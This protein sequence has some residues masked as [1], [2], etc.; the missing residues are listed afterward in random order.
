MDRKATL[1]RTP[2]APDGVFGTYVSDSGFTA[3]SLERPWVDNLQG[4]SC[5]PAGTYIAKWQ[6]SEKHGK[7]LYHLIAVPGREEIEMHP[8]NVYEQLRGCI[9]LGKDVEIF[10]AGSC[11]F[12]TPLT[13]HRGITNSVEEMAKFEADLRDKDGEQVDFTIEILDG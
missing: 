7:N 5:V 6:W 1:T 10:E 13:T 3:Q 8:C 11:H 12:A 9:A 2:S 4:V